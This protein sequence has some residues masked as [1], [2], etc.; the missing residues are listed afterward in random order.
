MAEA[1]ESGNDISCS[2]KYGWCLDFCEL[3][4]ALISVVRYLTVYVWDV[5]LYIREYVTISVTR[6]SFMSG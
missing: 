4:R 2:I 6:F 5:G 1:C 3:S